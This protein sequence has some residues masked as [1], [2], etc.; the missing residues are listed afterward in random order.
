[1]SGS[2][3]DHSIVYIAAGALV[4]LITIL[5]AGGGD[6]LDQIREVVAQGGLAVD[7]DLYSGQQTGVGSI[8]GLGAGGLVHFR[9][10]GGVDVVTNGRGNAVLAGDKVNHV[11]FSCGV[12]NN[13]QIAGLGQAVASGEENMVVVEDVQIRDVVVVAVHIGA[14]GFQK[15]T[16][17]GLIQVAAV[18]FPS[19]GVEFIAVALINDI[20][21]DDHLVLFMATFAADKVV[22]VFAVLFCV[23]IAVF[24]QDGMEISFIIKVFVVEVVAQCVHMHGLAGDLSPADGAVDDQIV[25]AGLGAGGLDVVLD[26]LLAVRLV[27]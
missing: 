18:F 9:G 21:R 19:P 6:F 1:M 20:D 27:S 22:A 11:I 23:V 5:G 24:A 14:F 4:A 8:A 7:L 2:R 13:V 26:H 17:P 15:L 10:I 12:V 25:A 3:L 16:G